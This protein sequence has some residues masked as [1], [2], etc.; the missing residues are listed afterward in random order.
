MSET[1][2]AVLVNRGLSEPEAAHKFLHPK[3]SDLHNP[4]LMADMRNA[5]DR[6]MQAVA[7]QDKV[8]VYGD[9]DVDGTTSTIVLK[10]ALSMVGADV[11]YYIPERLKD[12]YGLNKEAMDRALAEGFRL[13]ISV[14]TGIRAHEIVDHARHLGLDI[15]VTDHHLPEAALPAANAVLNP[16]RSDCCYPNKNLAGVG[17][18][19]KLV[20]ALLEE[21][22]RERYLPSFMKIAAIGTIADIVPLVGENRVIAKF[23]LQGLSSPK[24]AG[25]RALLKMAG[26][27]RRGIS[28]PDIAFKL[29][30][31]INAMGRMAGATAVVELFDAPDMTIAMKLATEIEEQN[32]KRQKMSSDIIAKVLS[33]IESD[34]EVK[35]ALVAVVAGEGWHRGVIGIAASRV[36]DLINRPAIVISIEDGVGHGSARSIPGFHLLDAMASCSDLFER[37]GGHAQ[38][39]G[40]AIQAR[41]IPE[42]RHRINQFARGLLNR[43][44][45]VPMIETDCELPIKLA[46]PEILRE[47]KLFEPYGCGNPEP[48]FEA[49]NVE[50]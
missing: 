11:S 28:S 37:F 6:I 40:L 47:L 35:D 8:L 41:L 26:L 43:N 39:A 16:K 21:T 3:Q 19:F 42:L 46:R 4:F 23:G 49:H 14:D 50:V 33:A 31:R 15:I 9:Y 29:A 1:T 7:N 27:E 2:A 30:P 34:P 38:A 20:Q 10:R 5:V 12:G 36:I 32:L 24:N 45:L 13:I 48:V 44:D 22:G 17:V 18:A 25:L